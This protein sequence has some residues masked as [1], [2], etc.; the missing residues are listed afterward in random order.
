M[1][2]FGYWRDPLFLIGCALYAANRCFIKPHFHFI[3]FHSWFNDLLLIPCALPLLL[4][5][6]RRFGL[7]TH[8]AA[9]TFTEIAAHLAGWS[10]L[11]EIIGPHLMRGVTGDPLDVMAYCIG[12]AVAFVWW[13]RET[14]TPR[15]GHVHEL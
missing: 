2:R 5:L 11:F 4:F 8:D 7:R 10:I 13:Q 3:V 12:G 14:F 1:K 9:P 6:H 15:N